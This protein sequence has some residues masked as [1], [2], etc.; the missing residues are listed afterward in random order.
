MNAIGRVKKPAIYSHG[1]LLVYTFKAL[2]IGGIPSAKTNTEHIKIICVRVKSF[3]SKC[4]VTTI[5]S[6]APL[7][8]SLIPP[9][10][11]LAKIKENPRAFLFELE[12][13]NQDITTHINK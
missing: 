3:L 11:I 10:G 4:L 9:K 5:S 6:P 12:E 2:I 8:T 1:R 7:N 13:Y